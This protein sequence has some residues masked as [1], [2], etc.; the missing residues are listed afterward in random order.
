MYCEKKKNITVKICKQIGIEG[1]RTGKRKGRGLRRQ[2]SFNLAEQQPQVCLIACELKK[3][4]VV[5][6]NAYQLNKINF[7]HPLTRHHVMI[8]RY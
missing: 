2:C 8:P 5:S 7:S 1:G 6:I 4:L 3:W